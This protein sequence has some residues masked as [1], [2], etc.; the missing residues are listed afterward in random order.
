MTFSGSTSLLYSCI[1]T[2]SLDSTSSRPDPSIFLTAPLYN[3]I[4]PTTVLPPSEPLNTS[5][6]K[7]EPTTPSHTQSLVEGMCSPA[8]YAPTDHENSP[9]Q[10]PTVVPEP[11]SQNRSCENN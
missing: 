10:Q 1:P 9:S 6:T 4:I 7:S 8:L 5:N 2:R 3:E 11:P